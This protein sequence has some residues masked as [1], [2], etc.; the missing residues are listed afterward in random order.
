MNILS[1]FIVHPVGTAAPLLWLINILIYCIFAVIL[2]WILQW[3]ATE[4]GVP[5]KIIH[6]LGILIFLL[7][8]LTLFVGCAGGKYHGPDVSGGVQYTTVLPDGS[9]AS[10]HLDA[11]FLHQK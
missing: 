1:Y 7:V 8:L 4:F 3:V 2:W 10:A 9:E 5:A 11:R 6:L